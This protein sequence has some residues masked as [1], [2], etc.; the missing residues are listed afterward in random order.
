MKRVFGACVLMFLGFGAASAES[1]KMPAFGY[2]SSGSCI[3]S[4]L[5]FNSKLEPINPGLSWRTTFN[6]VGSA[7]ADGKVTEAGQSVDSASFGAGPRMHSPAANAYRDTFVV[8]LTGP[9]SD[10][11]SSFQ[12]GMAN[13]SFI[14]GPNNG[15]RFTISNFEL[16]G[17]A[18]TN[19]IRTY[20]S[21]DSPT[22]QTVT[23]SNGT[24][25]QRICT[26][27]IVLISPLP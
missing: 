26:M 27:L 2:S 7:D 18:E 6:A 19:G 10:G 21:S 5:G 4:P 12:L 8:V 20:G 3:A 17:W 22:I 13:G 9:N 16:K 15:V 23:L 24:K 11:S 1:G 14:A 25:F